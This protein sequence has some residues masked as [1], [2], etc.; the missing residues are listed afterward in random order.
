[1]NK[2]AGVSVVDDRDGGRRGE[3][4]KMKKSEVLGQEDSWN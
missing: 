3:E 1:M 4:S 2:D